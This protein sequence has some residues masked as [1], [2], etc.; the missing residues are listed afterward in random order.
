MFIFDHHELGAKHKIEN[1][2]HVNPHLVGI[3]GSKEISGAGV[4]YNFAKALNKENEK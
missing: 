3:D 2:T 4:V 1:I